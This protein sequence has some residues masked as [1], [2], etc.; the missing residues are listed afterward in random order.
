LFA[1]IHKASISRSIGSLVCKIL[2]KH[3]TNMSSGNLSH[4]SDGAGPEHSMS[5]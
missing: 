2:K 4:T 1:G 5:C 3:N